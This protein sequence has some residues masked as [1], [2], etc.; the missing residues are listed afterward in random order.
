MNEMNQE[1]KAI[2]D[3]KAYYQE[4]ILEIEN[5]MLNLKSMK[6]EYETII[7]E[8]TVEELKRVEVLNKNAI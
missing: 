6:K 1:L 5:C 3:Q 4:Q 7:R 8:L 2:Q